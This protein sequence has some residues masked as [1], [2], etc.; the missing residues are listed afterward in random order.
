MIKLNTMQLKKISFLLITFFLIF[1]ATAQDGLNVDDINAI[2]TA[3]PFLLI[4]PDA[5]AG[6]M[7]DVG[8]A[9]S[10]DFNSQHHNPAKAAFNDNELSIGVNITPWMKQI[11]NDVY[12][13]G[14]TVT[15]KLNETSAWATSFKFFD[16]GDIQLTDENGENI[17][18]EKPYELSLDGTYALKLNEKYSMGVTLR[19]LRSDF[20]LKSVDS[21]FVTVNSFAVDIS[22]YYESYETNLG[23]MNAVFR[24][25]FNISNLGP[26]VSYVAGLN[27]QN[28][29]PTNLKLGFGTDFIMDDYN[30]I[31]VTL[32]ST[33]LLVP[34]P[35][36]RDSS[37]GEIIAGKDDNVDFFTGV[38]QSFGDAPGGFSE[39]LREFT[40]AAGAEYDYNNVFALRLGYFHENVTKGARNYFTAGAGFKFRSTTIDF[41]YL[42]NASNVNNPLEN[43]LRF[44]LNFNLGDSYSY[45]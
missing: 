2:T 15:N 28:F 20:G 18:V 17:S 35:P 27:K 45:F 4:T 23:N 6:A 32:E 30:K 25:G 1:K 11:V 34:T 33:K 12:L 10:P 38:F 14:F 9:T 26:K 16:Y 41:S 19:Y 39:E 29:I 31:A 13:G 22:G 5:R 42:F 36:E 44:S 3:A 24:G 40:Y 7:G 21:D 37:T 8:V 43:T